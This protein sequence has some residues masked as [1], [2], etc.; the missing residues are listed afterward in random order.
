[1]SQMGGGTAGGMSRMFVLLC[2]PP[3]LYEIMYHSCSRNIGA[4]FVNSNL[5]MALVALFYY[6]FDSAVAARNDDDDGKSP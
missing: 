5:Q 1:M 6:L 2:A 3:I 4:I